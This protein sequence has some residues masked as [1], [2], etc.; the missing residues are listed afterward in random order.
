MEDGKGK[1][2]RRRMN[3]RAWQ[4]VL[5]RFDAAALTVQEFCRREGLTRGS[6]T[7]W[8]SRLRGGSKPGAAGTVAGLTAAVSV[9]EPAFV[10]LGSLGRADAFERGGS[11]DLRI[12]LGGGVSLH[13]VRR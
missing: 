10:D 9:P 11:V 3:E 12:E 13:L 2:P 4:E 5:A 7:R 6:F 8:Q 1:K